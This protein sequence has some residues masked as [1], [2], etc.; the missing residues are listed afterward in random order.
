MKHLLITLFLFLSIGVASVQADEKKSFD[1]NFAVVWSFI[2]TDRELMKENLAAQAEETLNLW[3]AGVIENVYM[4]TDTKF[5]DNKK[6]ANVMFFIKADTEEEAS[7]IL[8]EMT[9]VKKKISKYQLFPVGILWLKS[10]EGQ[11]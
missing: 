10:S 3:K 8:D 5:S 4:D 11:Q 9:F 2:T 1:H 6:I 7:K